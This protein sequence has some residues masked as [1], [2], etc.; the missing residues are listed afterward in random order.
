MVMVMALVW[1]DAKSFKHHVE[2]M[3]MFRQSHHS[4]M[5]VR[6]TL[7]KDLPTTCVIH[8]PSETGG[9]RDSF[10][11]RGESALIP[12]REITLPRNSQN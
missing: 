7:L 5:T 2:N 11:A 1:N 3:R 6:F 9:A 12:V 4:D 10:S 8:P